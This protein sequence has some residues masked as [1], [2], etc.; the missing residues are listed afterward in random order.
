MPER[1]VV[2]F[3]YHFPP[4]NAIGGARPYRF[5]KYLS[6][7]GYRCHVITAADQ[8][9]NPT[10]DTEYVPDPFVTSP[11]V[12]IG[13]Q[14]E[15]VIR[16]L[17]FPGVAGFQW[18]RLACQAAGA[19]L[20]SKQNAEITIYST[21][22]PLGVHLAAL[23]LARRKRLKWIADFRD[24]L[25]I[26]PCHAGL[27]K[28]QQKLYGWLEKH[29]LSRADIV[30]V[31]TDALA[32]RWKN[33]YPNHRDRIHVIW[34]GFDP[35]DRIEQTA[36]PQRAYRLFSH[37]GALYEGRDIGPLLESISRLIDAGRLVGSSLRIR[38][39][40]S[41]DKRCIP[42]AEFLARAQ[43][44]GWLEIIRDQVPHHEARR[45]A[46]ESDGLLLVQ[47]H[48]AVL[49]PGKLFEYLRLRRPI[50]AFI[51]PDTPIERIL[52][53]SGVKYGC[54]YAGNSFQEMD[55][56]VESFFNLREEDSET[57]TWFEENFDAKKQTQVLD[58]L[59]CSIH[60]RPVELRQQREPR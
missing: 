10:L 1:I 2:M 17:L 23:L 41:T 37:V 18:S 43:A 59:I 35:A 12:G 53:Q 3:A 31:N 25:Y 5:Y 51:L 14:L 38:L 22:P 11:R 60:G 32:E 57:N 36:L 24:P 21:F 7:M 4:E 13:W 26:N 39:V 49:V 8:G 47:P 40:G 48:T 44:Q 29:L 52:K 45:M 19:F 46:Q 58:A 42:G 33:A 15:R 34:N 56:A 6:E 55:N 28:F 16:K 30:L 54:I 9:H 50:L 20:L 27:T